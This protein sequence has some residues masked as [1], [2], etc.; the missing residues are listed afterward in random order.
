MRKNIIKLLSITFIAV[1]LA[2]C[3]NTNSKVDQVLQDQMQE[4]DNKNSQSE[5]ES[6]SG[7]KNEGNKS[8]EKNT[9]N[10]TVKVSNSGVDVDLTQLSSTM[11]YSEVFN[12]MCV[13]EDY[14][15]KTVKM[16]GIFVVYANEDETQFYP[17][18]LILDATACCS[19]GIEFVLE[20]NPSYPEGYPEFE[21]EI[22]VTGTFETYV[23]DGDTYCRLQNAKIE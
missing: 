23:E 5:S 9:D 7:K 21:D 13:P 2:A 8:S 17:A 22:T 3:D 6:E 11:V 18:C 1:M 10:T 16:N 14:I 4:A 20:G 12:M 19:Q 15:G